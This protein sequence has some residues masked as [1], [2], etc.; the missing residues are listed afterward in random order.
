[1]KSVRIY[2]KKK[3]RLKFVSHLDMTRFMTRLL[4][5]TG[6]PIWFTEGFHP[7]AYITF[8]LPLSLGF[9]SEYEI[10]DTRLTDDN[11]PLEQV[12]RTLSAICPPD[13]EIISAAEPVL[14]PGKGAFA[15][16]RI[17]FDGA[18]EDFAK[19]LTAFLSQ[20]SILC[21]KTTK[22]GTQKEFDLINCIKEFAVDRGGADTQ[23]T[24]TLTAGSEQNINP[25]LLLDAFYEQTGSNPHCH[26]ITRTAILDSDG[27]FFK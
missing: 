6:L 12:T 23:L 8:A 11:F 21:K 26:S 18:G 9:E 19:N 22:R 24:V 2:Y 17:V 27:Q 13:L 1:M 7:H 10:M 25:T 5:K 4:Q 3:G 14:K 20:E 15:R 16:F